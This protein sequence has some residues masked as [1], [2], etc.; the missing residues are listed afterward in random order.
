M[1]LHST[2]SVARHF[3]CG[4]NQSWLPNLNLTYET[5]DWARKWF[6]D[7]IE[8][9]TQLVSFDWSNNSGAVYVKMG[10]SILEEK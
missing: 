7:F 9:K 3:I 10:G 4:N 5:L 8:G 6:I 1:I 2:L